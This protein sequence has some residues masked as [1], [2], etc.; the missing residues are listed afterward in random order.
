[1]T[2]L[3][4]IIGAPF[5]KQFGIIFRMKGREGELQLKETSHIKHSVY[6]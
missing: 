1:M 4:G 2:W 6:I 3:F 5:I